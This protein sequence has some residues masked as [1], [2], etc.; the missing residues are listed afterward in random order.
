L[1]LL[2]AIA[3]GTWH[4]MLDP[5]AVWWF[6]IAG[7]YGGSLVLVTIGSRSL[8]GQGN[9]I[10]LTQRCALIGAALSLLLLATSW[11]FYAS[12]L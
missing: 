5:S 12:V 3:I 7:L 10:Q 9:L 8:E 1:G 6:D 2:L 11:R 4:Q